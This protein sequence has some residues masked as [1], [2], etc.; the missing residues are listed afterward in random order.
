M[1]LIIDK[2]KHPDNQP[3]T[4]ESPL[5]VYKIAYA[6]TEEYFRPWY[7]NDFVYK[8][9][10][11]TA[12][13]ILDPQN[14]KIYEGYH[15]VSDLFEVAARWGLKSSRIGIF[16]IPA[17]TKVYYGEDN[18]IAAEQMIYLKPYSKE[19][20]KTNLF[21]KIKHIKTII[22]RI[23]CGYELQKVLLEKKNMKHLILTERLKML[24]IGQ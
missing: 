16:K 21:K 24:C 4:L 13:Q 2:E 1:C 12:K 19:R 3:I 17:G 15:A 22:K 10:V 20:R 9:N 5:Y 23:L 14:N 6:M 11:P 8:V 7:I 18:E